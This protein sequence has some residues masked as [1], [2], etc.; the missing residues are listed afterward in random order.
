M[1]SPAF[2]RWFC[3]FL[4]IGTCGR[5]EEFTQNSSQAKSEGTVAAREREVGRGEGHG[6][7]QVVRVVAAAEQRK[8][9]SEVQIVVPTTDASHTATDPRDGLAYHGVCYA[10]IAENGL[11]MRRFAVHVPERQLLPLAQRVGRFMALLWSA[12]NRRF[13]TLS[14]R[15][16]QQVV[17]VW[18]SR[19]GE[20]GGEQFRN[21]LYLYD[22][23]GE[24]SGIEWAR[25]LA[26]EYGHYLLP[27]PSGYTEPES[28][29]NGVLGERLFLK[30]LHDDLLAGHLQPSEVPFV[31]FAEL[32]DYLAK[33][34]APLIDQ[35]CTEGPKSAL[36]AGIDRK[37]MN[38]F[39]GLLLYIDAIY[40]PAVNLNM[41]DYLPRD[42][43]ERV[44]AHD[45]LSAFRLWLE[46]ALTFEIKLPKWKPVKIYLPRGTFRLRIDG[47]PLQKPAI[48]SDV[49]FTREADGWRVHIP[50][51]AW[52][53][54]RYPSSAGG[55]KSLAEVTLRWERL[56]V[57]RQGSIGVH[58]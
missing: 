2:L 20:A 31:T 1:W 58:P 42:R 23:L 45:F 7:C 26:H 41:L 10:E 3:V 33:Q 14:R 8:G 25:E 30:W 21:H 22:V 18:L 27:A 16:R 37:A 28:W 51:S 38:A 35:W 55:R 34:V 32:E 56:A 39:T 47:F 4:C 5:A 40:G 48:G 13:G 52:R 46:N 24:R 12:A 49:M 19:S 50:T 9:L 53:V 36:L 29:A 15:L 17:E 6:S 57:P 43:A 54:L 44:H 11:F